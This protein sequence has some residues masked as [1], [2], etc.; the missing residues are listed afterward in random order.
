MKIGI[1]GKQAG[2]ES[3]T[4]GTLGLNMGK[5]LSRGGLGTKGV[6]F[7]TNMLRMLSMRSTHRERE[8]ERG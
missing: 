3:S 4:G 8:R 7:R 6:F 1:D 5:I 2:G